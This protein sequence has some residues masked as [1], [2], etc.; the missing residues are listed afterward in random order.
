MYGVVL[1]G[2]AV[3]NLPVLDLREVA[4]VVRTH[5]RVCEC[6]PPELEVHQRHGP[7]RGIDGAVVAHAVMHI[8]LAQIELPGLR[9]HLRVDHQ[10]GRINTTTITAIILF[11]IS[12]L[13]S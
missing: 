10:P 7:H 13:L 5:P 6:I 2:V 1:F 4:D 12:T 8:G 11:L 9:R 3:W